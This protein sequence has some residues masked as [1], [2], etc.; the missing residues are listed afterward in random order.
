[1]K[2]QDVTS[3]FKYTEL[4][5][6]G[7]SRIWQ[8]TQDDGTFAII[9][10]RDETTDRSAELKELVSEL[11]KKR[12]IGYKP[13][14]GH[15]QYKNGV[16]VEEFSMIIFNITKGKA[17]ELAKKLNQESIIWKD[18]D[19]FGFLTQDGQEDGQFTSRPENMN[20]SD[21]DIDLYGS[22]LA[23]HKNKNQRKWFKFVMEQYKVGEPVSSIRNMS[24][25]TKHVKESLFEIEQQ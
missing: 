9:G 5:E 22:R 2:L 20:F 7:L 19:F 14:Y 3:K 18:K 25:G 17:L 11:S 13:L 21:S 24:T 10:S 23:K 4:V 12:N 1:M 15:Y 8:H 16:V 6:G